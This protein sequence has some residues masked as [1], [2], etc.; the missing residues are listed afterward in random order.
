MTSLKSIVDAKIAT[1][2][3]RQ[4]SLYDTIVFPSLLSGDQDQI[5]EA[6]DFYLKELNYFDVKAFRNTISKIVTELKD[7]DP[8]KFADFADGFK[9]IADYAN[10]RNNFQTK[11]KE[12]LSSASDAEERRQLQP[13]IDSLDHRRSTA[14]NRVINLFN[15]LNNVA[16]KWGLARPYPYRHGEFDKDNLSDRE[17]VANILSNQEPLLE[18]VN[19]FI[20]HER[21]LLPED[22]TSEM[23]KCKKMSFS[24]LVEYA[25]H[26][27]E[28]HSVTG[29]AVLQ[30]T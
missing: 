28:T 16:S 6:Y 10:E 12:L 3:S 21:G 5:S 24:E 9:S 15:Q 11:I 8:E 27:M 14:H 26:R 1:E 22:V 20:D 17:M 29:R 30:V 25:K 7:S 4:D 13:A 19:L 2:I 23:E 18:S